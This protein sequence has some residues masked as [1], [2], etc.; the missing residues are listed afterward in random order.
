MNAGSFGLWQP[1]AGLYLPVAK[2][3]VLSANAEATWARGDYPYYIDN[4][5]FSQKADR[6][7]SDIRA[8]QG[9]LN[10]VNRFADSSVLQTK[11]LGIIVQNGA[12]PG[13]S[14]SLMIS[15]YN[16]L[17]DKN[18]FI[19]SRYQKKI[20]ENYFPVSFRKIQLICI[21]NILTQIF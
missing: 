14:F 7:N 5:M 3:M 11:D 12:C 1:Y 18:F 9:E 2:N 8:F 16:G 20:N 15:Q 17:Q 10:M 6:N 19:Q 4:G 13:A 21:Q